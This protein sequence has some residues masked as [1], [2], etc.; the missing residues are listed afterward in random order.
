ME[1]IRKTAN[2]E[3][4]PKGIVSPSESIERKARGEFFVPPRI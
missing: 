1:P 3:R 2:A 4:N